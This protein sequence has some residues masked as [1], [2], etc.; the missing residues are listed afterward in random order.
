MVFREA[1]GNEVFKP[2]SCIC[3]GAEATQRLRLSVAKDALSGTSSCTK[4]GGKGMRKNLA[5]A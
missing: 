5:C 4:L 3:T 1:K 2:Q